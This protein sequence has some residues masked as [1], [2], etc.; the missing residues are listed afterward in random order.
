MIDLLPKNAAKKVKLKTSRIWK[1]NAASELYQTKKKKLESES[2]SLIWKL[3]NFQYFTVLQHLAGS[4][5]KK[6]KQQLQKRK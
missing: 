4:K 1:Q 2:E 5:K 6:K 3:Q